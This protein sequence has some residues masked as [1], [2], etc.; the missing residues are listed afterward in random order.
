MIKRLKYILFFILLF[1]LIGS[2][3]LIEQNPINNANAAQSLEL[4]NYAEAVRQYKA[5]LQKKP[6]NTEFKFKLGIAYTYSYIDQARGLELLKELNSISEKPS[7]LEKELAI[8]YFKNYLFDNAKTIFKTLLNSADT[9]EEKNEL[10]RWIKQCNVS[11]GLYNRPIAIR[12]ENLGKNVNS[13]APDYIPLISQDESMIFFSTRRAGVVGNLFDYGGY[14]TADIYMAKHKNNKYS[15]A[16]S[17]GSPNTYGNEE[18]A[19]NSENTKYMLYHVDSDDSYSDIF[20]SE[21]GRRSYMP[22]K[23]FNSELV[24]KK[25]NEPGGSLTN[26]GNQMFFCS[27]RDGGFGGFDIYFVKRLPHGA[28]AEPVNL[29]PEINTSADEKFPLIRE[30]GNVL[31]F[32]SSGHPGLG[33]LD[34]FKS[35]LVENQWSKPVNLGYPLNTVNDDPS[36]CFAENP[37]YAYI[38]TKRDDSFGDLDIYRVVFEDEREE[39]TLIKG[40]LMRA[41]SSAILE[42]IVID[43]LDYD[44]GSLFGS[45]LSNPKT[46][47]FVAILPPG[48]YTLEIVDAENYEDQNAKIVLNDKNDFIAQKKVILT[49]KEKPKAEPIITPNDQNKP[50]EEK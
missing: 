21:K 31:Y 13:D 46:G 45:Y 4:K 50:I 23:K 9:E 44:T 22:P 6:E 48:K 15:R 43:V 1:P 41:D 12:F 33:D 24:N 17:V 3:Q 32:S 47:G 20:V 18:T 26:D 2:A 37:R 14:R 28:W 11:K 19:G 10:E 36:I 49:L 39:L 30:G 34:L 7:G 42:E 5:L 40:S 25:T 8:A 35:I 29:G 16:R 27:D 38:S